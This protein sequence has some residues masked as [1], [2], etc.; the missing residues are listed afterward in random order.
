MVKQA[1]WLTSNS[2][3]VFAILRAASLSLKTSDT[4]CQ[5][6]TTKRYNTKS[7]KHTNTND[8]RRL[9]SHRHM[10]DV[11]THP[12]LSTPTPTPTPQPRISA[13]RQSTNIPPPQPRSQ[14]RPRRQQH[15]PP[16]H[17]PPLVGPPVRSPSSS[18]LRL[19]LPQRRPNFQQQQPRRFFQ[20]PC[21]DANPRRRRRRRRFRTQFV[22]SGIPWCCY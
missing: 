16:L 10:D 14:H 11:S 1:I 22:R 7:K 4:T 9:H 15:R 5:S 17:P 13:K 18:E 20:R 12:S 6:F 3:F 8:P 21:S 19:Q 2:A